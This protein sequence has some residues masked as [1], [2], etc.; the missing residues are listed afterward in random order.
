MLALRQFRERV[1]RELLGEIH[2]ALNFGVSTPR[3]N[4]AMRLLWKIGF[5]PCDP[6]GKGREPEPEP[7]ISDEECEQLLALVEKEKLTGRTGETGAAKG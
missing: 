1:V 7:P 3:A 2:F 5:Y 6:F 4:R